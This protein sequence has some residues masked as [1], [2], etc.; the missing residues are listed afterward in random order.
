MAG[1]S[2]H[3]PSTFL[4]LPLPPPI[5]VTTAAGTKRPDAP[6]TKNSFLLPLP[7][8]R[9]PSSHPIGDLERIWPPGSQSPASLDLSF[10]W[11][12]VHLPMLLVGSF[13]YSQSDN[14]GNTSNYPLNPGHAYTP[15]HAFL[16]NSA[17]LS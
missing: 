14:R 10:S 7:P 12:H 17:S 11:L 16:F 8:P 5:K 2:V 4:R 6:S 3:H 15:G 13:Q 9:A 1:S